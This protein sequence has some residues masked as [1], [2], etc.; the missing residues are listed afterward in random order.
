MRRKY[1]YNGIM[2]DSAPEIAYYIWLTDNNIQ[3]KY[4]P[5]IR[6]SYYA[7]GK[8]HYYEPDFLILAT[9]QLEDIKGDQFLKLTFIQR[10]KERMDCMK[11][12]NVRLIFSNEYNL[13]MNYCA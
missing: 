10:S 13:Y 7:N 2:F 12:N 9:N 6:L 4:H 11:R 3:F 5:S 1:T 8:K